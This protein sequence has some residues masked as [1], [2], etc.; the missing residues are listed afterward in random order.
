MVQG[1]FRKTTAASARLQ[2]VKGRAMDML[3]LRILGLPDDDR[4]DEFVLID[5]DLSFTR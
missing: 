1:L 3:P 2:R 4:Q 5:D